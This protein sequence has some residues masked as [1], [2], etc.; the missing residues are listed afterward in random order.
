MLKHNKGRIDMPS[1]SNTQAWIVEFESTV[2]LNSKHLSRNILI[3]NQWI[4]ILEH[5]EHRTAN[6]S[7]F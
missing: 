7:H 6:H 1:Q 2:N 3:A 5:P 4:A